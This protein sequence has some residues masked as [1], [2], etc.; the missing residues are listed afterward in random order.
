M[1]AWTVIYLMVPFPSIA[2]HA[3]V[4]EKLGLEEIRE[5]NNPTRQ[6]VMRGEPNEIRTCSHNFGSAKHRSWNDRHLLSKIW[7][8]T[9]KRMS[10]ISKIRQVT[11]NQKP[12]DSCIWMWGVGNNQRS[13]SY[14]FSPNVSNW[15]N[16]VHLISRKFSET[17]ESTFLSISSP[18]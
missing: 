5:E 12:K 1:F 18:Y 7:G 16:E 13:S 10:D 11:D 8:R 2:L 6:Q 14:V 3:W 17:N 9:W 15:I 4:E